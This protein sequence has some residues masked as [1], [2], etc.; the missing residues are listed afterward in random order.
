[1]SFLDFLNP[2]AAV[3]RRRE[4]TVARQAEHDRLE[5]IKRQ[6]E[7]ARQEAKRRIEYA[8]HLKDMSGLAAEAKQRAQSNVTPFHVSRRPPNTA[9]SQMTTPIDKTYY[10]RREDAA[11]EAFQAQQAQA[12]INTISEN[13]RTEPE[14]VKSSSYCSPSYS[15]PDTGTSSPS[16]SD[17]GSCGS[18]SSDSGGGCGSDCN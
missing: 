2:F 11:I 8:Q 12:L 1:M 3:R 15:A 6:R 13:S 7:F 18:S 17:S 9:P 16:S 4:E 10:S 14:P 5:G